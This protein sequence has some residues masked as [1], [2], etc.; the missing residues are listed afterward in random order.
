[1]SCRCKTR[2]KVSYK[3]LCF[4]SLQCIWTVNRTTFETP[5][6]F[7]CMYDAIIIELRQKTAV[8]LKRIFIQVLLEKKIIVLSVIAYNH[9]LGLPTLWFNQLRKHKRE[10]FSNLIPVYFWKSTIYYITYVFKNYWCPKIAVLVSKSYA[11]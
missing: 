4:I 6:I 7:K 8:K 10:F 5:V 9:T 11:F 2:F 1:M 3:R